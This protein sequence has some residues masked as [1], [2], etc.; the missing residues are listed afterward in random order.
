VKY[1]VSPIAYRFTSIFKGVSYFH[2]SVSRRSSFFTSLSP[3]T[4][5]VLWTSLLNIASDAYPWIHGLE[6]TQ[7]RRFC[8]STSAHEKLRFLSLIFLSNRSIFSLF[9]ATQSTQSTPGSILVCLVFAR[10][11]THTTRL[12]DIL[13]LQRQ[14]S[15]GC[16][17]SG[18]TTVPVSLR[19]EMECSVL[20]I[21]C[22]L[23]GDID[24]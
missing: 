15:T 17:T 11:V 20:L 10:P 23:T 22:S 19:H 3:Q 1:S 5:S 7:A 13:P 18:P 9:H 2:F 4:L 12:A 14:E 6:L 21:P 8:S 16:F 24:K